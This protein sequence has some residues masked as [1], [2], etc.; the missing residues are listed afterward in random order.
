[1]SSR[2][3]KEFKKE[4]MTRVSSEVFY[5]AFCPEFFN[6]KNG[7][8]AV[9]ARIFESSLDEA[10]D[11]KRERVMED[12]VREAAIK[13]LN[14]NMPCPLR[15]NIRH[16]NKFDKFVDFLNRSFQSNLPWSD[17]ALRCLN[18]V[19][20]IFEN[21][22]TFVVNAER[23]RRGIRIQFD[24]LH[25]VHT[26][27]VKRG[28]GGFMEEVFLHSEGEVEVEKDDQ[29]NACFESKT[30]REGKQVEV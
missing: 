16:A 20:M 2:Y 25:G 30:L 3:H 12:D 10:L 22:S 6:G 5:R 27:I 26:Q 8:K 21:E 19:Y 17:K 7:P 9:C 11:N 1:M 29:N 15:H 28:W 14:M 23:V 4:T 24:S 13:N 18:Y